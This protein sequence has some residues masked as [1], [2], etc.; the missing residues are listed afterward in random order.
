METP[1]ELTK[2]GFLS[3]LELSANLRAQLRLAAFAVAMVWC[4]TPWASPALALALGMA[5]ALSIGHPFHRLG[6]KTA[7]ILL[8]VC[9]VLLGFTMNLH[10]VLQAGADGAVFA[11]ISIGVTLVAGYL[12]GRWLK[13]DSHAS[14]LISVGTAICGGSAIAAVGTVID[15]PEEQMTVAMGTVFL[16]NAVA[17]YL[18][19][20]IGH[21]LGLSQHQFGVWA[22]I[23]IHDISSV[24]AACSR[25]GPAALTTGTAV[26]L[27]RALWIVPVSLGV[28]WMVGRQRGVQ[29]AENTGPRRKIQ[30]PWFIGLFLLACV[31]RSFWP[32]MQ[33]VSASISHLSTV[34]LTLTLFLIGA[35]LSRRTLAAV[36]LKPL[37][38][39]VLLWMLIAGGTLLAV[40]GLR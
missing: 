35:G 8:Q 3:G 6:H 34:G 2:P 12:L 23:S 11:V 28:A 10:A 24:V 19:V 14:L 40:A 38:Q 13:I 20:P 1:L 16:L 9:V 32:V 21:G 39:G 37:L 15:A 30:M 25:Y 17:L 22:G 26:K 33:D 5:L 4:L 29:A 36:G 18:F 27:S 31:V 7:K